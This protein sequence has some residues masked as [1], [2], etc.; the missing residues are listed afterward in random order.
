MTTTPSPTQPAVALHYIFDPLCGW[1][2]AA[3]PLV[4]AARGV[5][6]L[7][8]QWHAGGMLTGPH[9]RTITADW[10]E[11][12]M[13]HDERIHQLTGQP[14]G[15]AYYDGLLTRLGAVLDSEPP[16]TALLAAES[17]AGKG[18]EMLSAQQEAYYV[19]GR[20]ISEQDVLRELAVQIGL[21]AGGFEAACE[22]LRGW[23]T[24]EHINN[25]RQLMGLA[26]G[27]GF[28]TFALEFDHPEQPGQ[29][30]VQRIDIGPWLG[31][32]PGW[33]AQLAD[34]VT[35]IDEMTAQAKV[36]GNGEENA[37]QCGP[38]GCE[39]PKP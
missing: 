39:L 38:N 5:A 22:R 34:W 25:S 2:Y 37:P 1:C 29:R 7:A 26:Q 33:T 11:H 6:G 8:L 20:L 32:V 28:P 30:A 35:Q 27:Q 21:D 17:L 13:P 15:T 18:L 3:A 9:R 16:I 23:A 12:V 14:F 31:D 24:D 4:K 36:D 10:R 19:Q